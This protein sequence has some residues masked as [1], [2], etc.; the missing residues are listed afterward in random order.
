MGKLYL[1]LSRVGSFYYA[2]RLFWQ[3]RSLFL[4]GNSLGRE[5]IGHAKRM[6]VLGVMP[7]GGWFMLHTN[8]NI[9]IRLIHCMILWMLVIFAA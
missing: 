6:V 1:R 8:Q 7:T 9:T 5:T 2:Q 4:L 3:W